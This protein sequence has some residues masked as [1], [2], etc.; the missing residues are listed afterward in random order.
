MRN[1]YA[2][3]VSAHIEHYGV[4]GMRW[5]TRRANRQAMRSTIKTAKQKNKDAIAKNFDTMLSEAG[6]AGDKLRS[7]KKAAVAQ[8]KA[9]N[10]GQV[11]KYVKS[12]VQFKFKDMSDAANT[13]KTNNRKAKAAKLKAKETYE[14]DFENVIKKSDQRTSNTQAKL[15]NDIS[16]AKTKFKKNK[17]VMTDAQAK[18]YGVDP[19]LAK[20]IGKKGTIQT[21]RD[22]ISKG[23]YGSLVYQKD[24][25]RGKSDFEATA[26]AR[27]A[28]SNNVMTLG[29]ASKR[30][31]KKA[32]KKTK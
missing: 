19:K 32:R 3:D 9:G 18:A 11:K 16:S 4:V 23:S 26:N 5:G 7:T 1:Y 22:V 28:Q 13:L 10:K 27:A 15:K 6:K 20:Q 2:E 21:A 8:R 25:A 29:L 17:N 14:K 24:K 31:Q 12:A 30:A